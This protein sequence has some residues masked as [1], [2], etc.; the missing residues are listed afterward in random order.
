MINRET[1]TEVVSKLKNIPNISFLFC[2]YI[3]LISL[4]YIITAALYYV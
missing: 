3:Y 2:T 1:G 4:S